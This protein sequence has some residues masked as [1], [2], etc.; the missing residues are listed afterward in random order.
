LEFVTSKYINSHTH[1]LIEC[2]FEHQWYV[3]PYNITL[4]PRCANVD[5]DDAKMR[6]CEVVIQNEGKVVG[7]YINTH[8]R[9]EVECKY[10]HRWFAFPSSIRNGSFCS[11][12]AGNNN[13]AYQIK[14][15]V[16]RISL[17]QCEI[18]VNSKIRI[19]I[20]CKRGR[21]G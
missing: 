19:E 6:L 11:V 17:S 4:C 16:L 8:T 2:Q 21:S 9:I 1:V 14:L 12:C 13:I 15:N 18:N 7:E 3:F 20:E 5:F 10:G